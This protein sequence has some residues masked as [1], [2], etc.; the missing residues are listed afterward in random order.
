MSVLMHKLT[1]ARWLT[2]RIGVLNHGPLEALAAKFKTREWYFDLPPSDSSYWTISKQIA[3]FKPAQYW[4]QINEPV[5]LVFG[6]HDERVPTQESASAIQTALG[7]APAT[8]RA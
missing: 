3:S 1:C 7:S 6:A 5:L 4:R 8:N 2:A